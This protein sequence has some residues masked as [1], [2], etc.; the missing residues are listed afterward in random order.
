MFGAMGGA[1]GNIPGLSQLNASLNPFL[2]NSGALFNSLLNPAMGLS[3]GAG[4]LSGK[5]VS[6]MWMNSEKV[7]CMNAVGLIGFR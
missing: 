7:G 6:H 5:A 2:F 1:M 3:A 4:Q